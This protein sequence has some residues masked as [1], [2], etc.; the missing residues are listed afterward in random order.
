MFAAIDKALL[1]EILR[2]LIMILIWFFTFAFIYFS[3][4]QSATKTAMVDLDNKLNQK[5]DQVAHNHSDI[6]DKVTTSHAA[7][8]QGHSE[9]LTQ[10][11][12]QLRHIPDENDIKALTK[13]V[14]DFHGDLREMTGNFQG[15]KEL[16]QA[17]DKQIS[18]I[19][20][21]LRVQK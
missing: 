5:I 9:R 4:K 7:R 8:A 18:R 13:T 21:F 15:L 6:I 19:D 10:I 1:Y 12:E 2:D 11:E 16:F 3:K 20:D 14:S 17:M